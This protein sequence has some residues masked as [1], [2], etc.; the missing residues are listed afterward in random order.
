M[1]NFVLGNSVSA[2]LLVDELLSLAAVDSNHRSGTLHTRMHAHT[3]TH[4]VLRHRPPVADSIY[5][6]VS[7]P[8]TLTQVCHLPSTRSAVARGSGLAPIAGDKHFVYVSIHLH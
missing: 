7:L 2:V 5:F 1:G 6:K 8:L 3:D 4:R